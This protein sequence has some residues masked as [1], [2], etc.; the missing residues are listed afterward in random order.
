MSNVG[1]LIKKFEA[2]AARER[3]PVNVKRSESM[4]NSLP[5]SDDVAVSFNFHNP[6][7]DNDSVFEPA[8]TTINND[9]THTD[10]CDSKTTERKL[11]HSQEIKNSDHKKLHEADAVA[12]RE[13]PK[14]AS[15]SSRNDRKHAPSKHTS[16]PCSVSM[17]TL[18]DLEY[19]SQQ[20][21]NLRGTCN[22]DE[23]NRAENKEHR[24]ARESKPEREKSV[25]APEK[26]SSV[27]RRDASLHV[28]RPEAARGTAVLHPEVSDKEVQPRIK[29]RGQCSD[30]HKEPA[31]E[32]GKKFKSIFK[33]FAQVVRPMKKYKIRKIRR[34]TASP[35]EPI[36]IKGT[37]NEPTEDSGQS[38]K[39]FSTIQTVNTAA[40]SSRQDPDY[41]IPMPLPELKKLKGHCVESFKKINS[42]DSM[43][44]GVRSIGGL[45]YQN[46]TVAEIN[47]LILDAMNEITSE[48]DPRF[49]GVSIGIGSFYDK[50]KV[51]DPDE[52][53]F[54]YELRNIS[55]SF[56][57]FPAEQDFCYKVV[58][59]SKLN[60]EF[61][62]VC[63]EC[64]GYTVLTSDKLHTA[65]AEAITKA[66]DGA[67]L[68]DK[69]QH[70][71]F[72]SPRF[73]GVRKSG[74]AVTILLHYLNDNRETFIKVDITPALPV[75][76][77]DIDGIEW[78]PVV[79][80]YLEKMDAVRNI[81]LIPG[82]RR[83][84]WKLST[85]N[86]ELGFMKVEL[87]DSG[88]VR[89]TIRIVKGLH[90]KH[91]AVRG[92][93]EEVERNRIRNNATAMTK[94]HIRE[95]TLS[96]I[97]AKMLD[98]ERKIR[99]LLLFHQS[100]KDLVAGYKGEKAAEI[101]RVMED[102]GDRLQGSMLHGWGEIDPITL[103]LTNEIEQPYIAT[104]S[105][106]VKYVVLDMLFCDI[107]QD[108]DHSGPGPSEIREVMQGS[109][110]ETVFHALLQIGIKAKQISLFAKKSVPRLKGAHWTDL[111][112]E[113]CS[114]F[115][116][117]LQHV[118]VTDYKKSPKSQRNYYKR[119]ED[120]YSISSDRASQD[121]YS[122]TEDFNTTQDIGR[123]PTQ[124]RRVSSESQEAL[125]GRNIQRQPSQQMPGNIEIPAICTYCK[126]SRLFQLQI[127]PATADVEMGTPRTGRHDKRSVF[128]T[129]RSQSTEREKAFTE[130]KAPSLRV[131]RTKSCND[132]MI[133]D[134]A[135][136]RK[137]PLTPL[138][139]RRARPVRNRAGD[140]P[141]LQPP[142]TPSQ[143]RHDVYC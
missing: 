99:D 87:E 43:M 132:V 68:P 94:K 8:T 26:E 84:T 3:Q 80:N 71:G 88:K 97:I 15:V 83:Q 18:E 121:T 27:Y 1:A 36:S 4:R 122:F 104:K 98:K 82:E 126:R 119:D 81:H 107:L 69:L 85:A 22:A 90:Q 67:T 113:V 123:H 115:L 42:Y 5:V 136:R 56:D 9:S 137:T 112:S 49:R 124:R 135:S 93:D 73:S 66:L 11:D 79:T 103:S 139:R 41:S 65:F 142:L 13:T 127:Q 130:E 86:L 7:C 35:V 40:T 75:A 2:P 114:E 47:E 51:T 118:D 100:C 138:L 20:H 96:K 16:L 76:V 32:R 106:A 117:K 34:S 72:R 55:D 78:P 28:I 44:A 116:A 133:S 120:R 30:S 45:D 95:G 10:S 62:D 14:G 105:C 143:S 19:F 24:S 125:Y 91:L 110:K 21:S 37:G 6:S 25:S 131:K 141:G 12:L 74:P 102:I 54:L 101:K 38:S 57:C 39:R 31:V 17:G 63:E 64:E 134:Q 140:V 89:R 50:T 60:S 128:A 23:M 48:I 61:S 129:S 70:A 109:T 92:I 59:D 53:D 52:F 33:E 111:H 58:P 108:D 29:P 77:V 46:H